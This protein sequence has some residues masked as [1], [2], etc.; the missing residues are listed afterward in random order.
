MTEPEFHRI[1]EH[2]RTLDARQ[3]VRVL[4]QEKTVVWFEDIESEACLFYDVPKQRCIVYPAR[5]FICRLFGQ[6]EWM[7]CPLGKPVPLV[8][9]G[10]RLMLDYAAEERATFPQWCAALGHYD[11]RHLTSG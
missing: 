11:L 1:V 10:L 7:P 3:V 9:D 2:L 8:R 6:V 4:E 5:P